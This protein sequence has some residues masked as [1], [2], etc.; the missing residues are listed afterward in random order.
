MKKLKKVSNIVL[1]AAC[2][3]VVS[4]AAVAVIAHFVTGIE[5]SP[6]LTTAWF[7]FWGVEIIALATIK[8]CKTKHHSEDTED[9]PDEVDENFK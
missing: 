5:L 3:A 9:I 4:Y 1:I 8:N 2:T 7:S 6:T